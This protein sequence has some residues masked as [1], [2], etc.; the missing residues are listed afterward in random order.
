[1][2][3]K[4]NEIISKQ[5]EALNNLLKFL[6]EQH[7]YIVREEVFNMEIVVSKIKEASIEIAKIEVERRKITKDRPI[8]NIVMES[9]DEHLKKNYRQMKKLLHSVTLQ[10]EINEI[11]IKQGISYATKMLELI[12]PSR[13]V[14]RT[15]GSTGKIIR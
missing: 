9:N 7:S 5:I 6:E 13:C 1:M 8:S 15:Y 2:Y 4:L 11:L 3:E 12:N 10:K 14:S